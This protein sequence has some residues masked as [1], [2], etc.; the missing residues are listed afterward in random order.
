MK[1]SLVAAVL[2]LLLANSPPL[3]AFLLFGASVWFPLSSVLLTGVL[4]WLGC[5]LPA[6]AWMLLLLGPA[7]ILIV[8]L[9]SMLGEA[10]YLTAAGF[11][12]SFFY[13][14]RFDLLFAG[15]SEHWL[16]LAFAASVLVG[17]VVAYALA[18]GSRRRRGRL[19]WPLAVI[20]PALVVWS[21]FLGIAGYI[22]DAAVFARPQ[23]MLA[24]MSGFFIEPASAA[25]AASPDSLT[26]ADAASLP[27]SKN[28]VVLYGE[29]LER[30]YFDDPAFTDLTK[31]LRDIRGR[32]VDF[33][34]VAPGYAADWTVGGLVASQCGYPLINDPLINLVLGRPLP[35][36]EQPIL[37]G[38]VCLGDVLKA[39]G[40]RVIYV[41]GADTRF[42]GKESFLAVHGFD[43]ILG[44]RELTDYLALHRTVDPT[45][46]IGPWGY[47]D[48]SM[49]RVAMDR[50]LRL[51]EAGQPFA[52][53]A[54]TLDTHH[55]NGM[56]SPSCK[57][58]GDDSMRQAI[59]CTDRL[60]A[61]F[62]RAIRAGPHSARTTIVLL[63]DH[64]AHR[65]SQTPLM[66]DRADRRLT[67]FVNDDGISPGVNV[68][69]GSAFD[70]PATIVDLLGGG[71]VTIGA[72]HSLLRGRGVL[73]EVGVQDRQKPYFLAPPM[74]ERFR[75]LWGETAGGVPTVERRP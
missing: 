56:A 43:E 15:L 46:A 29:S 59:R 3:A 57:T 12:E 25:A 22:R 53:V 7:V 55:P 66:P 2:F 71:A 17:A 28:L 47:Q 4:L 58:P 6:T 38:A 19:V 54:L 23:G 75:D 20:L 52:L 67:F 27:G 65:T 39:N 74:T 48:Q 49:L 9:N 10:Y 35:R 72:G 36:S 32:S 63:S 70:I 45:P 62:V 68:N 73:S 50:F 11:S 69:R 13:H 5:A 61:E 41:G 33:P 14:V 34:E 8:I 1:T 31:E 37:P 40:Y 30:S 24:R 44:S 21:P 64:L 26:R 18:I 51:S 16:P 60:L 42:A